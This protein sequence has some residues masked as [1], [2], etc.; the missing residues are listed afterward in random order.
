[1]PGHAISSQCSSAITPADHKTT[2]VPSARIFLQTTPSPRQEGPALSE[3]LARLQ[4][5]APMNIPAIVLAAG[6]G[7]DLVREWVGGNRSFFQATEEAVPSRRKRTQPM[8]AGFP[9]D[10][11]TRDDSLRAARHVLQPRWGFAQDQ[12]R[13]A[14]GAHGLPVAQCRGVRCW[15]KR[16]DIPISHTR[17]MPLPRR[18]LSTQSR[19]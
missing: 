17:N 13:S 3:P 5:T 8:V 6:E 12:L 1:M 7:L 16:F 2:I 4:Y 19:G 11:L 10:L 14:S 15:H 18:Q 9:F